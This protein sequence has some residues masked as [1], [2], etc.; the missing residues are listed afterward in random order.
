MNKYKILRSLLS[1]AE[2]E[3]GEMSH[4]PPPPQ[5]PFSPKYFSTPEK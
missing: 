3:V 1:N 4:F 2:Y 5:P